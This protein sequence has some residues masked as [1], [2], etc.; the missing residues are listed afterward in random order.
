[1]EG[2]LNKLKNNTMI[3]KEALTIIIVGALVITSFAQSKKTNDKSDKKTYSE[4]SFSPYA[5]TAGKKEQKLLAL[6]K[7]KKTNYNTTFDQKIK[8]YEE[9]MEANAKAYKK[10]QKELQK[11]QYSDFSYFGH[12]RK[13][14]IR[15]VGKRKFCKECRITH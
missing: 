5:P 3:K 6:N 15:K 2:Y 4:N 11:P 12:K 10:K 14:K 8:E 9:R 1:M 13:P 7:K